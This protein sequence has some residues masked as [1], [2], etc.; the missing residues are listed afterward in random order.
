MS[1]P[2]RSSWSPRRIRRRRLVAMATAVAIGAASCSAG[3]P[4][5]QSGDAG[6]GDAAA[7]EGTEPVTSTEAGLFVHAING[8]PL[9]LD[10]ARASLGEFGE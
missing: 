7:G 5:E 8:E 6:T 1:R 4:E 2:D 3:T 10:P 9:S